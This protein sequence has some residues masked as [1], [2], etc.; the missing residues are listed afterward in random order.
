M[1]NDGREVRTTIR[2]PTQAN[3]VRR[4]IAKHAPTERLTFCVANLLRADGWDAAISGAASVIHVAAP[5]PASK[6]RDQDLVA[7]ARE[8]VRHVLH[9]AQRALVRRVVMTSSTDAARPPASKEGVADEETWTDLSDTSMPPYARA[10]T[11]S[12][13][14]A[15][16]I[17]RE[18]NS[19]LALTT[20]LP[21]LIQGPVL[22]SEASSSLQ[23][24]FRMLNGGLPMLP[25]LSLAASRSGR[26]ELHIRCLDNKSVEGK[27]I[28]ASQGTWWLREL[29]AVLKDRIG[30][31]ASKVSTRETPD[32]LIRFAALFN[33]D[34]RFMAPDLGRRHFYSSVAAETLLGHPLMSFDQAMVT[35]AES[36]IVQ[37]LV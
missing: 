12:E 7:S 14:D 1:L 36:L 33:A 22:D 10:K 11:L 35:A 24:P 23:W 4:A 8:G 29:A 16:T 18:T 20:V 27:R 32:W 34:A 5:T 37:S 2:N 30:D 25:R 17:A 15:W 13:Q 9:A 21:G 26:S 28:I 6:Y 19:D 3:V 31:K